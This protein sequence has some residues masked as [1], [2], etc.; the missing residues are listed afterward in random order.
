MQTETIFVKRERMTLSE[1]LARH[2]REVVPGACEAVWRLNQN[3]A[4]QGAYLPLNV[5]IVVPLKPELTGAAV[6]AIKVTG[7]FD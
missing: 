4:R 1:L 6:K 5:A 2:Y 3:L 7:L